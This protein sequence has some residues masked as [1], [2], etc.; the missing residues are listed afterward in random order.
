MFRSLLPFACVFVCARLASAQTF[1]YQALL[2]QRAAGM[3]GAYTAVADDPTATFYNP[4][5]LAQ[6][7]QQQLEVGLPV[8]TIDQLRLDGGL[9]QGGKQDATDFYAQSLPSSV[10][11]AGGIGPLNADGDPLF[12]GAVSFYLPWLHSLQLQESVP[13]VQALH[14]VDQSEQSILAG[15]SLGVRL[16]RYG[17]GFSMFYVAQNFSWFQSRAGAAP[18]PYQLTGIMKGWEGALNFRLGFIAQIND[19]WRVGSLV[20]LSSVRMFGNAAIKSENQIGGAS[21]AAN[22]LDRENLRT[23]FRLPWELRFGG[24]YA[25]SRSW[26]LSADVDVALPDNLTLVAVAGQSAIF[27]PGNLSRHVVVNGNLGFDHDLGNRLDLRMGLFTDF[28]AVDSTPS[29]CATQA[30]FG[31]LNTVGL[32][33]ALGFQIWRVAIDVGAAAS[34]GF[35]HFQ[36]LNNPV[37]PTF[38]WS[39]LEQLTFQIF[40]GGNIGHLVERGAEKI[41]AK[42]IPMLNAPAS[43]PVK[44]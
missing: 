35:G 22:V 19:H 17:V 32:T 25:A 11:A 37:G 14:I 10:G 6:L 28:S 15:P 21:P 3:G 44:H 27:F 41:E 24:A 8:F 5:G 39:N 33:S 26:L 18:V 23:N 34:Y 36:N 2:G 29:V 7:R 43:E 12:V 40:V 42:M 16:G 9:V 30:C 20:S 1:N 13:G 4:A 31:D 38:R